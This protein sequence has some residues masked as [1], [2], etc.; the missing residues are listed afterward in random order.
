M[1]ILAGFWHLVN[2]LWPGAGLALLLWLVLRWRVRVAR[3]WRALAWLVGE[4]G[5]QATYLS[6]TRG[7]GGQNLI[8][9]EQAEMLGVVRT[10]ELLAA[11]SIDG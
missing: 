2:F 3:P 11:R 5:L 1:T 8:G 10:G 9:A 7:G 4:R 6:M